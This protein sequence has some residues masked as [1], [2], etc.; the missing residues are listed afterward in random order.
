MSKPLVVL[1]NTPMADGF[2]VEVPSANV[3]VPVM[4]INSMLDDVSTPAEKHD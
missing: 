1:L 4:R 2:G 3:P